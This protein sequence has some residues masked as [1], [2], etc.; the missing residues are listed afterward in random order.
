MSLSLDLA[1]ALTPYV[2]QNFMPPRSITVHDPQ[3]IT[4]TVAV[5]SMESLGVSLEELRLEVPALAA[6]PMTVLERW[7]K[8]LCQ[9]ITYLLE[10]LAPLEFDAQGQEVLIRSQQPDTSSISGHAKYYE[11]LLSSL[12]QGRFCLRRYLADK[13]Q[14]GR[15]P[16]P[17]Q[18]THEQL[19][20]LV[21]DL[22]ATL[23]S[24]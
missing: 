16:V 15:Q 12:G 6:A 24:P 18:L 14:P 17:L 19:A 13:Q 20:K 1:A 11:V 22:V 7:A 9:R 4:L 21:N 2:G 23:P 3:G 10:T 5:I 8:G